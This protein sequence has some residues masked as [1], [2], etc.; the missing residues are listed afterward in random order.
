MPDNPPV[1]FSFVNERVSIDID[2]QLPTYMTFTNQAVAEI[3]KD[4]I[5]LNKHYN[6]DLQSPR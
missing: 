5:H 4:N 6:E 3:I 2:K 1:P